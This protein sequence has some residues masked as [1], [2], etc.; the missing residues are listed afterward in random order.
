[1]TDYYK[2]QCPHCEQQIEF[3]A[4]GVGQTIDCPTCSNQLVLLAPNPTALIPAAQPEDRSSRQSWRYDTATENQINYLKQFGY[5][6]E[7][8]ITKG[9]ASE[10]IATF[11]ED[12]ERV[13]IRDKK[14]IEKQES[15]SQ[16][17]GD[18]TAW[19]LHENLNKAQRNL[20]LVDKDDRADAKADVKDCL[21]IRI[22]FWASAFSARDS[23]YT[24]QCL[25]L[26]EKFGRHYKKPTVKQIGVLLEAL[27]AHTPNWDKVAPESFFY[28]LKENFPA[29]QR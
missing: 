3:P 10:L 28:T 9:E 4:H 18:H 26:W 19:C 13:K 22:V 7:R 17:Y 8:F 27:D 2:T 14:W 11:E 16:L 25:D 24:S 23:D 6:S 15:E 21:R 12:P 5:I 20:E 29:H 1:M